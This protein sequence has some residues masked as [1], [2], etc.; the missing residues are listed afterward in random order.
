MMDGLC[1]A[2]VKSVVNTIRL[3][4]QVDK[5]FTDV[6]LWMLHWQVNYINAHATSTIVDDLAEVNALKKVF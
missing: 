3:R 2:Y 6:E 5:A 4:L 1:V